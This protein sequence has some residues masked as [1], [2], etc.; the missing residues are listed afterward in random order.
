M[1][2]ALP[3]VVGA[4]F[5]VV[6]LRQVALGGPSLEAA[7]WIA[8]FPLAAWLATN[9]LVPL[10]DRGM[11]DEMGRRLHSRTPFDAT[12]RVFVG[13]ARPGYGG[14]LDPHEDVGYLLFH[15]DRLEFFGAVHQVEMPRGD[16]T[17]VR[18]RAN[19]HTWV[20]LGRWVSVEGTS[21]GRPVRLD[22]E[23]RSRSTLLGN[24]RATTGLKKRL[25][26]WAALPQPGGIP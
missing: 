14:L 6:G 23:P 11:R 5:A 12:E 25:E 18:F 15:P 19:P 13:F 16:V 22:V 21:S 4:P 9:L 17:R 24:M 8:G 1:A 2:N 3:L 20:G 26:E 10:G 7:A